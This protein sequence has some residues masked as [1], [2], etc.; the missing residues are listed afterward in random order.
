MSN[1]FAT[2]KS[3]IMR[4]S[5]AQDKLAWSEF[6]GYYK[7]F[8]FILLKNM[9]LS[10]EDCEDLTQNILLKIWKKLTTYDENKAKFRTWLSTIIRNEAY[11]HFNKI[12]QQKKKIEA[13][14]AD[15]Q[16]DY[17]KEDEFSERLEKEWATYIANVAMERVKKKF[18]GNAMEVFNLTMEGMKG[19]EISKKLK[20]S[21]NTVYALR[22]RVKMELKE[23]V[24][25]LQIE[26]GW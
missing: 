23:E 1:Q 24:Q 18:L 15:F 13:Y 12:S 5:D 11:E 14:G 17:Q 6:V 19:S 3:L 22:G 26:L 21:E 9:G 16:E 7:T 10:N 25:S 4:A 8:I 20:I 2:R